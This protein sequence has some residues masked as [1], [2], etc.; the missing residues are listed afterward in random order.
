YQ[1]SGVIYEIDLA[2]P[3][4]VATQTGPGASRN[5]GA[6]CIDQGPLPAAIALVKT[7]ALDLGANGTSDVGDVIDYRFDVTN[8][9]GAT[10]TGVTVSDPLVASVSC[11]GGHPI[12]SLAPGASTTCT[13]AYAITQADVDAGV[14]DNTATVAGDDQGNPVNDQDSHS[15]VIPPPPGGGPVAFGCTGDAYIVQNQNAQLTRVD[16]SVSPFVFVPIG[17]ATG[18]EINNLGFRFTDGLLYALELSAG[19]NVQVIQIDATGTVFGLG[20]P[21]GL[22]AGPR[23]DA[24]D[25]SPDGTTMYITSNNQALYS[26]DLTSVPTLPAV[27]SVAVTGASGF[28]FDWAVNPAD[29]LLYGGDSTSGQLAVL[30]PAT[31]V[32]TD[33]NVT[34]LPSGSGYGGAWFDAAGALFLYQ[35]SGS[36]YEIDLSGPTVV[37]TQTGPGASRNDG[38]ACID[39]GPLPAAID[40]VKTG[41]LDLGAN[42]TS[43]PG[44]LINYSFEITNTGGATLTDVTVDDPLVASVSCPGGHPIP[45]LSPGT[46]VTCTAVYAITQADVDAGVRDNTATVSGDD[47]AIPVTGQDSHSESIPPPPGSGP[48]PFGCTGDAYIVQNQNAQLT[49]VDQSVS[50]FVFVDVGQPTGIEINNLGFRGTDGLLYGVELSSGGNIQIVRID[51]TGTVY[52]LGRPPSLPAGPRFDAGDVS[53]DGTTMYITSNN[54]ALYSLDLTSLPTLP[55]VTSVAV[56]GASGFVFDWAVNP[57]DGLL[58]GGDSTSGQLATLDPV[59]GVRSDVNV[60]GLPSGAGYGG[61]W[62]DATGNLFLYQNGGSLFEI[63][64]SGPTIVD[65]QTGPGATRNDGAACIPQP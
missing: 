52:G 2:G 48:V 43:D 40:L 5:D 11:P 36:L 41:A 47:Q 65:S 57:A 1:N 18:I 28:V 33:V 7:G 29:G 30:D 6:A 22:P 62:F 26:L 32:R 53:P 9:G 16:P 60:A 10:L 39:Q 3:T 63:D 64:L 15:E 45:S 56:S 44:D 19:G 17:T 24:G 38:A 25:V 50:P 4:V 14:R 8:T 27:A 34:G 35:N 58:Y 12:P 59:S 46:T 20:R 42:G 54:Q 51:A 49:R 37:N 23:F 61:A 31:G 55:A 21:A 13:A